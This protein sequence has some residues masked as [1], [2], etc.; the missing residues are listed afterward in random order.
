MED[1]ENILNKKSCKPW[2]CFY[3]GQYSAQELSKPRRCL[4]PQQARLCDNQIIKNLSHRDNNG[5]PTWRWAD[6]DSEVKNMGYC[7]TLCPDK[8]YSPKMPDVTI[9]VNNPE[10]LCNPRCDNNKYYDYYDPMK[11]YPVQCGRGVPQ[12]KVYERNFPSEHFNQVFGTRSGDKLDDFNANFENESPVCYNFCLKS[13]KKACMHD[14]SNQCQELV[15]LRHPLLFQTK[16][17]MPSDKGLNVG[18]YATFQTL[19]N[20]WNN[21]TKRKLL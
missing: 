11:K 20:I 1:P 3:Q 6:I 12:D 9:G 18:P 16:I 19:E 4:N 7:Q 21:N 14:Y 17:D 13:K 5:F 15:N 2:P 10:F 8:K